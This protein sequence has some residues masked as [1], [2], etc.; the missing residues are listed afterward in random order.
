MTEVVAY[1]GQWIE[2]KEFLEGDVVKWNAKMWQL[3]CQ[4]VPSA[5]TVNQVQQIQIGCS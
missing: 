2:N 1:A 4:L 5:V 3:V